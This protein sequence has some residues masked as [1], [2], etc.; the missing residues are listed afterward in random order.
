MQAS[1]QVWVKL[2]KSL[3]LDF[4]ESNCFKL[5]TLEENHVFNI[6]CFHSFHK[7]FLKTLCQGQGLELDEFVP[8]NA[9]NYPVRGACRH[10]L[11]ALGFRN[12]M[13][14]T[15]QLYLGFFLL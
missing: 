15:S 4:L 12:E 1:S 11:F 2:T 5:E 8:S 7:Y 14:E 13:A 9:H 10:L 3:V 6:Y